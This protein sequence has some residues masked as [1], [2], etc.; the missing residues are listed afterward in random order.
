MVL[1]MNH[2][3]VGFAMMVYSRDSL[4]LILVLK[5]C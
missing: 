1:N 5:I 3:Y 4:V 2:I